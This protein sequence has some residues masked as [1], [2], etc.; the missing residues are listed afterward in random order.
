[1]SGKVFL[2]VTI[3]HGQTC[4][5]LVVSLLVHVCPLSLLLVMCESLLENG[6]AVPQVEEGDDY[7]KVTVSRRV[8]SEET[9]KVM[10]RAAETQLLKQKQL[11]CLGMIAS[12]E[13]LTG[14]ELIKRLS[15]KDSDAL[16]SW[17][18]P[19]IDKGMVVSTEDLT[20]AKEYRVAPELLRNSQFKGKTTLKRIE[21]Y[22]IKELILEDLKIYQTSPI[23]DIQER[24]GKEI[25]LRK[26]RIQLNELINEGKV[27]KVG[28]NRWLKFQYVDGE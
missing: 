22:R 3:R 20:N 8:L 6:K 16:R 26:I 17:L 10:T 7:V 12:A 18:R 4:T 24:I 1:M 25:T 28:S 9:I 15:L 11:I 27:R 14:S 19:L 21:P 23:L 2:I 5:R 13:S